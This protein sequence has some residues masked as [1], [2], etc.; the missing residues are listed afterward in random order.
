[1]ATGDAYRVAIEWNLNGNA[2][3]ALTTFGLVEGAGGPGTDP[4]QNV[5]D[6][7]AA[8]IAGATLT[9]WADTSIIQAIRVD[10]IQPGTYAGIRSPITAIGGLDA[11]NGLPA[12]DALV[13][14]WSTGLKGKANAGRMFLSGFSE[15]FQVRG[16]WEAGAQ[17]GASAFASLL[18]DEYVS[19]GTNYQLNVLSYVPLSSP[20]VLRAA[21]PVTAFHI[22][23]VVRSMRSRQNGRGI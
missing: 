22:D 15:A 21:V 16:F 10:N 4:V 3:I 12:Q 19:D 20:R 2:V 13:V 14:H 1:M 8:T 23:N 18:F 7:V 11:A 5:A 17:D 9:P 6:D